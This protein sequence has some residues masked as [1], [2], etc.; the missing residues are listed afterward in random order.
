MRI[1]ER[2]WCRAHTTFRSRLERIV[3]CGAGGLKLA[4]R[5]PGPGRFMA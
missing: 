5:G 4:E 2:C 1:Y 3:I